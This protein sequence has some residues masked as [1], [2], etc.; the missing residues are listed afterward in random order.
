[1]TDDNNGSNKFNSF[2]EVFTNSKEPVTSSSSS[3]SGSGSSRSNISRPN[4]E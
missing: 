2:I 1:M 4:T 3:G